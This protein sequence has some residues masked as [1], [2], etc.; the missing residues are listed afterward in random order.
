MLTACSVAFSISAVSLEERNPIKYNVTF[1]VES[2]PI[3]EIQVNP[4]VTATLIAA[5][6]RE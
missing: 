3:A 1:I 2:L 4:S 6:V 5:Q